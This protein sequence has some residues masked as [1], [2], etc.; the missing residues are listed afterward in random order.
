MLNPN[1]MRNPRPFYVDDS[2]LGTLVGD[3]LIGAYNAETE[4]YIPRW[5]SVSVFQQDV[6]REG[7][8]QILTEETVALVRCYALIGQAVVMCRGCVFDEAA[9]R[10]S[11]QGY[12][13]RREVI[14]EP[15][16]T[17]L[18]ETHLH[19]LHTLGVPVKKGNKYAGLDADRLAMWVGEDL[20]RR[21]PLV[22]NRHRSWKK[23]YHSLAEKHYNETGKK[24]RSRVHYFVG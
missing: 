4:E 6:T 2:G 1:R 20:P 10:L 7:C 8:Y 17:R 16:Q 11:E 3:A 12:T 5:V 19:Y 21:V 22:K 13:I 9:K 15:L 14:G 23:T 18:G 24:E